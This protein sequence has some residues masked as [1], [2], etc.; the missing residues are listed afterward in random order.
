MARAD[1]MSAV[2]R[3]SSTPTSSPESADTSDD[4]PALVYPTTAHTGFPA[5]SRPALCTA[6]VRRTC[7]RHAPASEH[8]ETY[9]SDRTCARRRGS[10]VW[11]RGTHEEAVKLWQR[12][13]VTV[14]TLVSCPVGCQPRLGLQHLLILKM[15][16]A[17]TSASWRFRTA[18]RVRMR[19][20]CSCSSVSPPPP[21]PPRPPEVP[22]LRPA[23]P[24]C[25]QWTLLSWQA[26]AGKGL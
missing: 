21:L 13:Q 24:A 9:F 6:R 11:Q 3:L 19:L 7:T 10:L 16:K 20:R 15:N 1:V 26:L 5:R 17:C 23:L 8:A 18:M 4:F 2:A 14:Q 12:V 22:P 25:Q